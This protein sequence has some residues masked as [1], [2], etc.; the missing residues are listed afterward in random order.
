MMPT[1]RLFIK[2][3]DPMFE[4]YGRIVEGDVRRRPRLGA[5][6]T[7]WAR[8]DADLVLVHDVRR[9]HDG[10]T[11]W[12]RQAAELVATLAE[13]LEQAPL[14][15]MRSGA[16]RGA[17]TAVHYQGGAPARRCGDFANGHG[18]R[19][20]PGRTRSRPNRVRRSGRQR[21][22]CMELPAVQEERGNEQPRLRGRG[23]NVT[24][25]RLRRERR[26]RRRRPPPGGGRQ[27][28]ADDGGPARDLKN[29]FWEN[30][31]G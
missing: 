26:R 13:Y 15:K 14:K 3:M 8:G 6:T 21:L 1:T 5:A 28:R 29:H 19:R 2:A 9:R 7:Q 25:T 22:V 4:E 18:P 20:R 27:R 10:G 30:Q 11:L 17:E 24:R 12:A 31:P 23:V 16:S